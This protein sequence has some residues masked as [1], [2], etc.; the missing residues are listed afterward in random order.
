MGTLVLLRHG[1][2]RWNLENR[3]TGWFDV[4]LSEQ[5]EK[6]AR[7]AGA[8]IAAAGLTVDT[9]HTSVL[10]RAIRTLDLALEEMGRLWVPVH[11]HW[12]LNERHYGILTGL[13][14]A[15]TKAAYGD[16][17]F[18][19]WR[20]SYDTP[21]PPMPPDHEFEVRHDPRYASLAPDV[22]PATECLA[23]VV[24]RLLPYWYD[25]IAPDLLA[26]R[27]TLVAAHGNSLRAL[28]KHLNGISD[29]DIAGLEIPTGVPVVIDLDSALGVRSERSLGDP[30]AIAA[31]ADAVRRQGDR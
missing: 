15:E 16:R 20:R 13:D 5:G 29:A 23:D 24:V 6:E 7:S 18:Q 9:A 4:D 1:Q 22:V 19:A 31:A 12:R 8:L 30:D 2:S 17:Q 27:T 14:K 26:E 28:M 25:A 3:F 11:R 21:P 10:T